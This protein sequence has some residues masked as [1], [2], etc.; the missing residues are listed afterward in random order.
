VGIFSF[1]G[2]TDGWG[3]FLSGLWLWAAV[4][5]WAI[6]HGVVAAILQD[7]SQGGPTTMI[8][9]NGFI[10]TLPFVVWIYV[11]GLVRRLHDIGASAWWLLLCLPLLP[12]SSLFLLFASG[13]KEENRFGA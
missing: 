5:F 12:I 9:G 7:N 2:R 8:S 6:V 11:A 10:A 3:F 13:Q 1:K 4:L